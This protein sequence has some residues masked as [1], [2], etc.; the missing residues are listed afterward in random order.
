MGNFAHVTNFKVHCL[1]NNLSV[2]CTLAAGAFSRN[3][4]LKYGTPLNFALIPLN[5]YEA[6]SFVIINLEKSNWY[7]MKPYGQAHLHIHDFP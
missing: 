6:I 4:D 5:T 2:V 1:R 7:Q 3:T